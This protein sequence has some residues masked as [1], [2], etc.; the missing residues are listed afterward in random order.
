[1]V[2]DVLPEAFRLNASPALKVMELPATL[3]IVSK[4]VAPELLCSIMRSPARR[5]VL[6][7][8]MMMQVESKVTV[9]VLRAVAI[10]PPGN[11]LGLLAAHPG[12]PVPGAREIRNPFSQC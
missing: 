5:A 7:T 1:M 11:G 3:E 10:L 4:A 8:P 6:P 2:P 12:E 9:V